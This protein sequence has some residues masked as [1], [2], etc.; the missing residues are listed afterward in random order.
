[1]SLLDSSEKCEITYTLI[2]FSIT[3]KP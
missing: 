2:T 3:N 1:V